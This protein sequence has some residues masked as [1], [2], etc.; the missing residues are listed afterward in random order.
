MQKV[1]HLH[2]DRKLSVPPEKEASRD[3]DVQL[4]EIEKETQI[5]S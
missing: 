5:L 4:L 3:G 2:V 1:K